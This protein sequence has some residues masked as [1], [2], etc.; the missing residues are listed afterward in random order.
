MPTCQTVSY[1][2]K[3]FLSS[4]NKRYLVVDGLVDGVRLRVVPDAEAEV[5]DGARQVALHQDVL[6]LKVAVGDG[7]LA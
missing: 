2:F 7:R 5:G 6:G 1:V 3:V 4:K